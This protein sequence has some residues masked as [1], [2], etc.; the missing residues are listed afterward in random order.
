MTKN[1]DSDDVFDEED[2][3]DG[4]EATDEIEDEGDALDE[5]ADEEA[6]PEGD[7]DETDEV[8]DIAPVALDDEDDLTIDQDVELALDE[9]MAKTMLLQSDTDDDEDVPAEPEEKGEASDS[10]L[11]KQDDE[12]RCSSCRLLKK[13]SQLADRAKSLCRDCV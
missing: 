13:T 11:P 1:T 4:F 12:F 6:A 5:G 10:V 7:D 3:A 9:V 2:L 8:S